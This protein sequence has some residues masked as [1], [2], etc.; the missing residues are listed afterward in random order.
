MR[1]VEYHP[2]IISQSQMPSYHSNLQNLHTTV[3]LWNRLAVQKHIQSVVTLLRTWT[4]KNVLIKTEHYKLCTGRIC[5]KAVVL[6][7]SE[8][9]RCT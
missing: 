8:L 4:I 9:R 6:E 1:L 3:V 5:S 7:C 2:Y